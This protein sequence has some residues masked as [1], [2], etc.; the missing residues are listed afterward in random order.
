MSDVKILR[1]A[2]PVA[3]ANLYK[4]TGSLRGIFVALKMSGKSEHVRRMVRQIIDSVDPTII[5]RSS[6]RCNYSVDDIRS[7]VAISTC[8]SDVLR[9]LHLTSR[10][11]NAL[12]IKKRMLEHNMDFSHFNITEAR[13]R[14]KHTWSVSD[15]F[16]EHSPIPRSSLHSH[17]IRRNILG[18]PRCVECGIADKYNGKPIKLTIDHINGVSDDN[19]IEN[20]RWLCYNCHSQTDTF[21]G[22]NK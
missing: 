8:M 18:S 15:I 2:D 16:V 12:G 7:A 17:V 6:T 14:N 20:L 1:G 19:R 13:S 21:G 10:G 11:S 3:I 22:K 5:T 4:S 9:C